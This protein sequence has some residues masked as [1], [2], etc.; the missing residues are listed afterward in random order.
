MSSSAFLRRV[1]DVVGRFGGMH[2]ID[3]EAERMWFACM[4]RW[5]RRNK[6][7]GKAEDVA[8]QSWVGGEGRKDKDRHNGYYNSLLPHTVGS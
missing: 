8:K 2:C 1:V 7:V 4:L 5:L 6:H 3:L